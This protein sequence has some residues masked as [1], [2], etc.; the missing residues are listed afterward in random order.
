MM[1]T[2]RAVLWF[3]FTGAA[4]YLT[5]A[6]IIT[7]LLVIFGRTKP[8]ADAAEAMRFLWCS[9]QHKRW[10]I[11]QHERPTLTRFYCTK[12]GHV[13]LRFKRLEDRDKPAK[14]PD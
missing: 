6:V 3:L 1:D 7:L 2:A 12:C 5:I 13:H 10:H 9:M 8:L 14:L 11:V 4:G